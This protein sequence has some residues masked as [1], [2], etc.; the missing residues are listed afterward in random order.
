VPSTIKRGHGKNAW[1]NFEE[2]DLTLVE[3]EK[4]KEEEEEIAPKPGGRIVALRKLFEPSKPEKWHRPHS[5]S[6][7][8]RTIAC[9]DGSGTAGKL[10]TRNPQYGVAKPPKNRRG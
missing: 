10:G 2:Q 7:L 9:V 4:K 8:R 5:P 6:T 3:G 1:K